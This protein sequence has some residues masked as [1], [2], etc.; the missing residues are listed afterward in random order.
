M[1][2]IISSKSFLVRE[3]DMDDDSGVSSRAARRVIINTE[4]LKTTRVSA[5]DVIALTPYD[6]SDGK[7]VSG[8]CQNL[9]L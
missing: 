9:F 4:I 5:G 8:A 3:A 6:H 2:H 7:A 1:S